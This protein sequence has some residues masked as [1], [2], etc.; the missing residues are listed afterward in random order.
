MDQ[1]VGIRVVVRRDDLVL[2]VRKAGDGRYDLPHGVAAAGVRH[3]VAA[4]S[5]LAATAGM[6]AASL[7]PSGVFQLRDP[8]VYSTAEEELTV[9]SAHCYLAEA[10]GDPEPPEGLEAGWVAP[11][12]VLLGRD[13]LAARFAFNRL[14][15]INRPELRLE[16]LYR[17]TKSAY[18]GDMDGAGGD[19]DRASGRMERVT[20]Y[21]DA[22]IDELSFLADIGKLSEVDRILGEADVARLHPDIL[23]AMLSCTSWLDGLENKERFEADARGVIDLVNDGIRRVRLVVDGKVV[24]E[25]VRGD[26]KKIYDGRRREFK[27]HL[28]RHGNFDSLYRSKGATPRSKGAT[29][30]KTEDANDVPEFRVERGED[31]KLRLRQVK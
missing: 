22:V 6:R 5:V 1:P 10:G 16:D 14:G 23:D 20:E 18:D 3:S 17:A 9:T 28:E 30:R 4:A 19:L 25:D 29:V 2:G 24:S 31:G 8:E 26:A 12:D 21:V 27:A 13:G 11:G 15:I 7:S